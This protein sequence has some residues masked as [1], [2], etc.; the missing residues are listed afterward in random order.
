MRVKKYAD[1]DLENV[2]AVEATRVLNS[3]DNGEVIKNNEIYKYLNV[4]P[5]IKSANG[6]NNINLV[7]FLA[8]LL[9]AKKRRNKIDKYY[10]EQKKKSKYEQKKERERAR[11]AAAAQAGR[12]IGELPAIEDSER[13]ESCKYDLKLFCETYFP[14]DFNKAWSDDHLKV[15]NKLET[16]VLEKGLFAL[17][18]ARGSGKTTLSE[19]AAKWAVLYGHHEYIV[20]IGATETAAQ[21][22]LRS[23][24][25]DFDSNDLLMADFPEVCYPINCIEGIKNRCGGQLYHGER[26]QMQLTMRRLILPTIKGSMASGSVIDVAGITGRIRGMKYKKPS[27]NKNIRPSL[28]LIDDPQTEES[29]KSR[30][31]SKKRI[32]TLNQAILGLAGPG[33]SISGVMP[34]TVIEQED[35]ADQIL[36]KE[37]H[38]SWNGE[39]CK[40]VYEF[41]TN[42]ELW[43]KYAEIYKDSMI[44]HGNFSLATEFYAKNREKM[45]EGSRCG[46]KERFDAEKEISALQHA[47]NLKIRDEKSFF[48]E[49]QNE[50]LKN[51]DGAEEML[52]V[53]FI[54]TKINNLDRYTVPLY[55][56]VLTAF[57]DIHK[58]LLFYC[59][60]A[61]AEDYTSSV[62]DYGTYPEQPSRYFTLRNAPVKLGDLFE[63]AGVEGAI[64]QGLSELIEQICAR[65]YLREDEVSLSLNCCTIDANWGQTSD[66]IYQ[67]C[68]ESKYKNILMPSHGRGVTASAKPFSEYRKQRGDK[69]GN[70][71][72]IT[73]TN[74][75][76]V[77]RHYIYDTNYYKSFAHH[78]LA[79]TAGDKGCLMLYGSSITEH[80]QFAEHLTSEYYVKTSGRGRSVN[81]WKLRPN[82]V[83]NHWLDCLTGC[84]MSANSHNV[85]LIEQNFKKTTKKRK[86]VKMSE[87]IKNNRK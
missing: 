85:S 59:V 49:Y 52:S 33:E 44:M 57:I 27:T 72:R 37:L 42:I 61:F 5:H 86:T 73:N 63:N 64:Y 79:V 76:R 9:D 53:D 41:P 50:P 71:W 82:C 51:D 70:N 26:T 60:V 21:D 66:T 16:A 45:D 80:R 69:V 47:M 39:R 18:M 30:E 22:I 40:M 81:E 58:D 54:S 77:L 19:A 55:A 8:Y 67:F 35:M 31:Q 17:A 2:S 46:W 56:N 83:D 20:I 6:K 36:N 75:K 7:A 25:T 24:L 11:N 87:L 62:I 28:V 3:T 38:P 68:R 4:A 29:A 10:L 12:D 13:K 78:R 32:D 65:E 34:C 15:I 48:S 14:L 74:G 84:M 23:I 1:I 43:E